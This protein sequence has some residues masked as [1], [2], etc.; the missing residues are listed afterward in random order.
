M[1]KQQDPEIFIWSLI[2]AMLAI[3][4]VIIGGAGIYYIW[5]KPIGVSLAGFNSSLLWGVVLLIA[6]FCFRKLRNYKLKQLMGLKK[7]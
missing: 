1:K 2:S 5:N 4:G 7:K 3:Y 6:A